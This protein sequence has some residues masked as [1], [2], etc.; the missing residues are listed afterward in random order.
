ML[1]LD[2]P[3]AELS[4]AN[5]TLQNSKK[6]LMLQNTWENGMKFTEILRLLSKVIQNVPQLSTV[7]IQMVLSQFITLITLLINN[8]NKKSPVQLIATV[9][10]VVSSSSGSNQREITG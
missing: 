9:P 6:T 3:N 2:S 7:S 8:K 10:N 4:K 1:Y 5:V